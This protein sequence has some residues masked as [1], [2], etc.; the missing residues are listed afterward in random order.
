MNSLDKYVFDYIIEMPDSMVVFFIRI[1]HL[2]NVSCLS[3]LFILFVLIL[4]YNKQF[5]R[6]AFI[7]AMLM[8][9]S[10][11]VDVVHAIFN[12]NTPPTE[13]HFVYFSII[14]RNYMVEVIIALVSCG[15]S[16]PNNMR[17]IITIYNS[18][19]CVCIVIGRLLVQENYFTN[20]IISL[21][22]CTPFLIVYT[23]MNN[24]FVT[25]MVRNLRMTDSGQFKGKT[26]RW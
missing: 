19:L 24:F 23:L 6:L 21:I 11:T 2:G 18:L 25:S 10:F 1:R 16:M 17:W 15:L 26:G 14:H 8:L 4:F 20:F 3:A 5:L 22:I 7:F 13:D 9:A 12:L